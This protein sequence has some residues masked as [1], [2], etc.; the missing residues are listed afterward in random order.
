[1]HRRAGL[2]PQ[3]HYGVRERATP[4]GSVVHFDEAVAGR[5]AGALRRSPGDGSDHGGMAVHHAHFDAD[6]AKPTGGFLF[7][8]DKRIVVEE[9]R[10]AV[11]TLHHAAYRVV[12]EVVGVDL[13]DVAALY[14][15]HG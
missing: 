2:A 15:T 12:D 6:P 11:E 1:M 10:M 9:G 7:E 13:R 4:Q 8:H 3:I 14:F 5:D